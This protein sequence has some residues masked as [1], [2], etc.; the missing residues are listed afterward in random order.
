MP[1]LVI[2]SLAITALVFVIMLQQGRKVSQ[3]ALVSG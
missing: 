1:W 3:A 2:S